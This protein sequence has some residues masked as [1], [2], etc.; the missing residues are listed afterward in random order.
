MR[1]LAGPRPFGYT[2]AMTVPRFDSLPPRLVPLLIL[3]ASLGALATAYVAQYGFGLEPCVLCLTQRIPYA[4]TAVLALIALAV[5]SSSARVWIVGLSG[6]LFLIGA[7]LAFYHVGVE[8]HWWAS[9]AS[10]AGKLPLDLSA[11][12]LKSGLAMKPPKPCDV[13]DWSLFGISIAGYNAIF[14]LALGLGTVAAAWQM[15]RGRTG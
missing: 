6:G 5:R 1:A 3:G 9:V 4:V 13:V 10:C 11:A 7:G 12:D 8:Q 2:P 14:S 15:T